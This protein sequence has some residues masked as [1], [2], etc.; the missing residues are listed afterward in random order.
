MRHAVDSFGASALHVDDV[1]AIAAIV[2]THLHDGAHTILIKGS[3]F[4]AM[5]R[6]VNDLLKP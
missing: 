6:V 2:R 5:E 3:R 1:S 4:M